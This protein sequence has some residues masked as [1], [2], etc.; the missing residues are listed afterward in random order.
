M[1][2]FKCRPE[3][4]PWLPVLAASVDEWRHS[5]RTQIWMH[6]KGGDIACLWFSANLKQHK[7]KNTCKYFPVYSISMCGVLVWTRE[8]GRKTSTPWMTLKLLTH[9]EWPVKSCHLLS[10]DVKAGVAFQRHLTSHDLKKTMLHLSIFFIKIVTPS[11]D[12]GD[13]QPWNGHTLK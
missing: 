7:I 11:L 8:R 3:S 5:L 13:S 2:T 9:I 10:T 12:I 4:H 6:T 1:Y